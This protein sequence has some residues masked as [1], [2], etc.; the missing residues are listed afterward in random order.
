MKRATILL[1]ATILLGPGPL[2]GQGGPSILEPHLDPEPPATLEPGN[3]VEARVRVLVPDGRDVRVFIRPLT[4]DALTDGYAASGSPSFEAGPRLARGWFTVRGDGG[5]VDALRIRMVDAE[6]RAFVA[7][8]VV[9]VEYRF[10][11]PSVP[12]AVLTRP[13]TLAEISEAHPEEARPPV[14]TVSPELAER[15]GRYRPPAWRLPPEARAAGERVAEVAPEVTRE[16]DRE[17]SQQAT[18][19]EARAEPAREEPGVPSCFEVEIERLP[20]DQA[21]ER[22]IGTEGEV[23]VRC[24]NG[25]VWT[26]TPDG[27]E[28]YTAPDGQQCAQVAL[29][30]TALPPA[31]P[32]GGFGDSPWAEQVNSW[33]DGVAERLL[34]RIEILVGPDGLE[35]YRSVEEERTG[36]LYHRIDMRLGYLD[37]LM[38]H[39]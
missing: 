22:T 8:R 36:G 19:E 23:E 33:L 12:T 13:E 21:V 35:N 9:P 31:E 39:L 32:P 37:L 17:G 28:I 11:R 27:A 7:E 29:Y 30:A 18:E 15:L 4:D 1:T 14:E 10:G 26:T 20:C 2:G 5:L 6:T 24:A 25:T 16:V 3:R 34:T 38:E